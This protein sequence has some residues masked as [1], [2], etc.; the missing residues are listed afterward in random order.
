MKVAF[1]DVAPTESA[2][3]LKRFPQATIIEEPLTE[4]TAHAAKEAEVV[5]IFVSSSASTAVIKQLP[6]LQHLALRSTGYNHV[7]LAACRERHISIS[8]VPTYGENT[9]AEYAFTLML[10]LIR[11]L[12]ATL[13][14]VR[15]GEIDHTTTMGFDLMGKTLGVVGTGRIGGHAVSIGRG[16]GMKVIGFDPFP[17]MELE[18]QLGF[19]YV[20]FSELL[21]TADIITIHAPLTSGTKHL[22]DAAAFRKLQSSAILINTSRGEIIDTTALLTALEKHQLAGVGLDVIEGEAMLEV[23]EELHLIG[24]HPGKRNLELA[25]DI[26]AL[27]KLPNVIITP[28]N[29]FNTAEAV[30]RI[31]D[32]TYNNIDGYLSGK[33]LNLLTAR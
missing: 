30:Q 28:H 3:I 21:K 9:V 25:A 5:S 19:T 32:T 6:Q 10:A 1:F 8:T 20:D 23:S 27:E 22:F 24:R 17:R 14:Q 7:D 29:A 15:N 26:S 16:F 33:P 12:P 4:A 31:W 18:G 11:K 13:E 2:L